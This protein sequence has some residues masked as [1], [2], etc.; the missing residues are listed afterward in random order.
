MGSS[1][2]RRQILTAAVL[3]GLMAGSA[4]AGACDPQAVDLRGPFGTARFSVEVADDTAER[5]QGLMFRDHLGRSAGMLFVYEAPQRA[6]FWMKN[7]LLPLDMIF[8]D[9]AGRVTRVHA[10]AVPQDETPIDGGEDVQFV[11]EVNGGLAAA[12]GIAHGAEL[13]HPA[14]GQDE[15]VWPCAAE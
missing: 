15:A 12:I 11:L 13:R 5:A 7:T 1:S 8:A 6:V 3:S 10:N 2:A 4:L 9:A 14:I